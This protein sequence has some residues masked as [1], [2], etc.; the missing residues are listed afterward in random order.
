MDNI[1][2]S[3]I[4]VHAIFITVNVYNTRTVCDVGEFSVDVC[5]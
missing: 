4:I 3:L 1:F 2:D 5:R